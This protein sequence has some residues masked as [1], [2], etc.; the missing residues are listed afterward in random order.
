MEKAVKRLENEMM[1]AA[2]DLEFERAAALRDQIASI[3]SRLV[4]DGT[5]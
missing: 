2:R 1:A 4:F 5:V 3:R